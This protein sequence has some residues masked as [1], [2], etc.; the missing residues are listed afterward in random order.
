MIKIPSNFEFIPRNCFICLSNEAAYHIDHTIN[1]HAQTN[2]P[3]NPE[4]F[5]QTKL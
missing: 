2:N 1:T 4:H 3:Q 5:A